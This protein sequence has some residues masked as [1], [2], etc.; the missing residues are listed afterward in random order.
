MT[1]MKIKTWII[2]KAQDDARRYNIFFDVTRRTNDDIN[3]RLVEDGCYYMKVEEVL[4]ETEKALQIK[5]SSGDVIGSYKGWT[6]WVPK[7]QIM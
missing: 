1:E 6:L 2:D 4:K 3:Q 7:S 5:L